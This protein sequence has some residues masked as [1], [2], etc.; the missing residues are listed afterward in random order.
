MPFSSGFY[1]SQYFIAEV[2][3]RQYLTHVYQ[4]APASATVASTWY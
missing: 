3:T 1:K 4:A 2:E